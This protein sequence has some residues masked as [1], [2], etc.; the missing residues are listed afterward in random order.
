MSSL[1]LLVVL[2][3]AFVTVKAEDE[4][5]FALDYLNQFHYLS[6]SRSGNHDVEKAITNFQRFAG[7]KVTGRLDG[8]TIDLMKKPR[9]GMPD[10]E[11]GETRLRRYATSGKWRKTSLTYYIQH[12]RDLSRDQQDRIF[13]KALKYW[14]DVSSLSFRRVNSPS[15]ADLKISFGTRRHGGT[16]AER[17][18]G[19]PFDGPGKV[20]AHAYFPSDG[21][22]H[23]DEDETYTD[24]TSRGT[25]L[26]WVA[27]HEFGHSLGLKHSDVR[28]AIMYPYYTGYVPNMRLH[29]D[30][31][32]GIRSL[33]GA[34]GSV[35]GGGGGGGGCKDNNRNC[36]GWR[37][38]CRSNDYVKRNCKKTC[39]YC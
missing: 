32:N 27:T 16:S 13:A 29:S 28:G 33:Y 11:A 19:S 20:L 38:Y 17:T 3:A 14:A 21:R 24:G 31:I 37:N 2:L 36:P 22:A 26:L 10:D 25:N 1:P 34:G 15:S 9:C 5:T 30:D 39:R 8:A 4:E 35:G 12:G 23:F 18:C 6:M 7:L